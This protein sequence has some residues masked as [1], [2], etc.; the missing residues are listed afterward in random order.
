MLKKYSQPERLQMKKWRTCFA[1]WIPKA[2]NTHSEYVVFI[3]FPMGQWFHKCI[4]MLRLRNNSFLVTFQYNFLG[5][6]SVIKLKVQ[7]VKLFFFL[8]RYFILLEFD[9]LFVGY[10]CTDMILFNCL[11]HAIIRIFV[12][13]SLLCN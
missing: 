2:T 10:Y 8:Y 11:M 5:T 4:T 3:A 6:L 1:W 9:W 13:C 7:R 12:S